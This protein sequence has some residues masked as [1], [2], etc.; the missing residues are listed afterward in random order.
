MDRSGTLNSAEELSSLVLNLAYH[1][2]TPITAEF[3]DE[4]IADACEVRIFN[5]YSTII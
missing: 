1:M 5:D 4:I 2:D 3:L